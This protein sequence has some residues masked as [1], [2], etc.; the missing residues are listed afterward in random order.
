MVRGL[1]QR[2]GLNCK[3]ERN[4][5]NA[6]KYEYNCGGYALDTFSWYCP[7]AE[8]VDLFDE[9]ED[10]DSAL[11]LFTNQMLQDFPDMRVINNLDEKN[12]DEYY[13]AFRV[14]E[15]DF[16]FIKGYSKYMWFSKMGSSARIE[17]MT[18]SEVFDKPWGS[19]GQYD[20]KIVLF[21]KKRF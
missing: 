8:N 14:G 12:K 7:Y 9:L 16:H 5:K 19:W 15:D 20:S 18:L 17:R 11:E 10:Y 1:Y 2:D 21:A 6:I 4:I 13:V 3:K